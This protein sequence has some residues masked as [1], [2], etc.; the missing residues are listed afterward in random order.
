MSAS[1]GKQHGHD[2]DDCKVTDELIHHFEEFC[3]LAGS[4]DP[5]IMTTKASGKLVDDCLSDLKKY[6]AKAICDAS[7]FPY[8]KEHGKPHMVVNKDN[9][10]KFINKFAHEIAKRKTS[11]N[12]ID[13]KDPEVLAIKKTIC[14]CIT[15][16]KPHVHEIKESATGN[17]K[18]LT[19]ASKFTGTSKARFDK[20]GKG[21][22]KEAHDYVPEDSGYVCGYKGQGTYDS[23]H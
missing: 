12:K 9:V 15:K 13:D 21:K 16:E 20:D 22:G 10:D 18:G 3:T 6:D 7:V 11:N 5:K 17:V 4:K 8:C 1:K 19:D 23:S 2:H 14:N